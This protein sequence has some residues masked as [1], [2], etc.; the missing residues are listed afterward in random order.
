[1]LIDCLYPGVRGC[2]CRKRPAKRSRAGGRNQ[3]E[4]AVN[5]N[6]KKRKTAT[7]IETSRSKASPRRSIVKPQLA[8]GSTAGGGSQND[9]SDSD[10]ALDLDAG[11][12][13]AIADVLQA[14]TRQEQR[15]ATESHHIHEK[16]AV[17]SSGVSPDAGDNQNEAKVTKSSKLISKHA[18]ARDHVHQGHSKHVPHAAHKQLYGSAAT[19]FAELGLNEVRTSSQRHTRVVTTLLAAQQ[20]SAVRHWLAH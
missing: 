10:V 19:S 14:S 13:Q 11:D 4:L 3:R 17:K 9:G 8:V 1:M 15:I 16:H 7:A 18:L 20:Q 5:K 6:A 12:L 2:T